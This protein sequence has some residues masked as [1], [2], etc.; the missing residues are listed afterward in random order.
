[1]NIKKV[2]FLVKKTTYQKVE[3]TGHNWGLMPVTPVELIQ[4]SERIK[5]KPSSFVLDKE[6]KKDEFEVAELEIEEY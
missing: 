6:W 2:S 3:L 1:M 4:L 5:S